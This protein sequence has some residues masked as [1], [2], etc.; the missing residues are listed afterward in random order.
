MGLPS[1]S[2][3]KH[4]YEETK[5]LEMKPECSFCV[6]SCVLFVSHSRPHSILYAHGSSHFNTQFLSTFQRSYDYFGQTDPKTCDREPF[7]C[8][9]AWYLCHRTTGQPMPLPD[10]S[11]MRVTADT[12][13]R[14]WVHPASESLLQPVFVEITNLSSIVI[15]RTREYRGYWMMRHG[16]DDADN[17][18]LPLYWLHEPSTEHY[19]PQE[20]A[21][22]RGG[23]AIL[24]NLLDFV[25]DRDDGAYYCKS[26]PNQVLAR[27][28]GSFDSELLDAFRGFIVQ[29][30]WNAIPQLTKSCA[31]IKSLSS[32]HK[33][34]KKAV[35]SANKRLV[36]MEQAETRS[37]QLPWGQPLGDV[38]VDVDDDDDMVDDNTP[39]QGED[40]GDDDDASSVSSAI[41]VPVRSKRQSSP[42]SSQQINPKRQRA[43]R[44]AV[45]SYRL[46]SS[47]SEE[48]SEASDNDDAQMDDVPVNRPP[49]A[50]RSRTK[51]MEKMEVS[52]APSLKPAAKSAKNKKET[53]VSDDSDDFEPPCDDKEDDD[54]D[55]LEMDNSSDSGSDVV[56][57]KKVTGMK[58]VDG[59]KKVIKG[60]DEKSMAAGISAKNVPNYKDL[61]WDEIAKTKDFLDPC[62][63]EAT[64]D[65]IDRLVGGQVDKIAGLLDRALA[66]DRNLATA[67][68]PL[69]LGTACSGTDAPA[70]ALS[71]VKEQLE[72]RNK[73]DAFV[74]KHEFS[75]EK[76]PFKQAY[77]ARNFDSILYPD[78][79]RMSDDEPR[80]VYGQVQPV[81]AMNLFVAGTSCK[82]FSMLRSKWRID[83]EDKGC[84]G[85]TFLAAVEILF[86]EKPAM[87][88]FE[89]VLNAPWEK[90]SDYITGRVR[91]SEIDKRKNISDDKDKH[92]KLTFIRVNKR[93]VV[94]QVPGV[95]GVRCGATVKGFVRG[96]SGK[97]DEAR[98]PSSTS[99]SCTLDNLMTANK[100]SKATDTLVFETECNFCTQ[101]VKV[102]TKKYGLPQTRERTYMFVWR[103]TDDDI[104]DDLGQYW[105]QIVKYLESPAKHAI[106]AFMLEDDHPGKLV[107]LKGKDCRRCFMS[108]SSLSSWTFTDVRR[109]REALNGPPGRQSR[110]QAFQEPDFFASTSG[111]VKYN[112]QTRK[113]YGIDRNARFLTNW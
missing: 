42:N 56:K 72:L 18:N 110:R 24:S 12:T 14:G 81:P 106:T 77:L 52:K 75:C 93:I 90:M 15:D 30:L 40:D 36:L 70:L 43:A 55:D 62:G 6:V 46:D 3:R 94:D 68:C 71:L 37:N 85:E 32:N 48:E 53:R 67:S 102:D 54:D 16:N 41:P 4:R 78:I 10:V 113:V 87:S 23:L 61:S 84:S 100:I 88:I 91:L 92:A 64:D 109:Y 69:T 44:S 111:D 26:T 112:L 103:P 9:K 73:G 101:L 82:N 96:D 20:L 108:L 105:A 74:F 83:I 58:K 107:E 86:K 79:T 34:P 28:P 2:L 7:F 60:V 97:V 11:D 57:A 1:M 65:I 98:W 104:N 63:M 76:E 27:L 45:K 33:S 51:T 99:T 59:P 47:S 38:L 19:K 22:Y 39:A 13:L 80:D 17:D 49:A 50:K 31:F 21:E 35:L 89:N 66:Q 95:Y 29:Y 25:F 8:L 5:V